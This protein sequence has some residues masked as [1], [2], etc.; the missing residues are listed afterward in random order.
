MRN[1]AIAA[2][3]SSKTTAGA[4]KIVALWP[5]LDAN[6]RRNALDQL[7]GSKAGAKVALA[8]LKDGRLAKTDLDGATFEKLQTVLGPTDPDLA[9]LVNE[10]GA[11]FRPVLALNGE[12]NAWSE[13]NLTLEG[14]F[15]VECWIRLDPGIDNNDGILGVPGQL[16]INFYDSKLRVWVGGINDAIISKKPMTPQVWTH[17]AVT[18]DFSG[19]FKLY[20]DGELVADQSKAAPQKFENIRIAWTAPGKGT[21]GAMSEFRVWR[22]AKSPDVIRRDFDRSLSRSPNDLV[23]TGIRGF[24]FASNSDGWGKLQAGAKVVKTSDLPPVMTAEE[25]KAHDTKYEKFR[26]LAQAPGD[27]ARGKTSAA[28]CQA[29]H[30]FKGQG[31][32]IGPDLIGVGAMGID[33]IL[34]NILTPNAAM[35]NG[36]RIYRVELKSGDIVDGFF[37]SEDKDAVVVRLPGTPD[38]RIPRPE[39]RDAKYLRRSL[40]PEGLLDGM[41]EQQVIDLFAYLMSLK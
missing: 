16:D 34:R 25:A 26:L 37:V 32:S 18:R 27:P 4:E 23:D 1:E 33:A 36:Y 8:A 24:E 13:P 9:P 12:D 17:V 14:A 29:C 7:A 22:D 40:M 41:T 5:K 6:A 35:E 10:L 31:A 39:I 20:Q 3:A 28:L 38:R 2:L 19:K 11:L 15:T 21:R 30:L